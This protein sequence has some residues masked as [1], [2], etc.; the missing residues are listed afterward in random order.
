MGNRLTYKR[1]KGWL[2]ENNIDYG[3]VPKVC[4]DLGID[5]LGFEIDK[6][7][8]QVGNDRLQGIDQNGNMNLF[9]L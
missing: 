5:F 4:Q 3:T 8:W 1:G 6:Y 9:D 7:W 2:V